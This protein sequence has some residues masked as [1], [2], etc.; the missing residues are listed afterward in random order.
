MAAWRFA[1]TASNAFPIAL[2]DGFKPV[3]NSKASAVWQI[4]T[5]RPLTTSA[6]FARAA[7]SNGVHS[8]R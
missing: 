8:G 1:I 6:S 2:I 4:A 3:N 7:I 5:A